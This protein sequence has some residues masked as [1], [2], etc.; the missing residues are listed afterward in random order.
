MYQ[1]AEGYLLSTNGMRNQVK[2][3]FTISFWNWIPSSLFT[4]VS[5][6]KSPLPLWL[7]QM[8]L[9]QLMVQVPMQIQEL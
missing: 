9:E 2:L 7:V 8:W 5:G 6:F 1:N 3:A 4:E